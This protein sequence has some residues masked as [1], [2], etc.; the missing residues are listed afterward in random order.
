MKLFWSYVLACSIIFSIALSVIH[1]KTTINKHQS[2]KTGQQFNSQTAALFM[3][4]KITKTTPLLFNSTPFIPMVDFD[5]LRQQYPHVVGWIVA[6]NT[7]INYPIVLGCDNDFYLRHLPDGTPHKFGAIFM[8]Y[9]HHGD[10]SENSIFIYGHN[11]QSGDQ[12][13]T[14]RDFYSQE[15]YEQ[16][17]PFYIYTP[18]A[19]YTLTLFAGYVLDARVATPPLMFSNENEFDNYIHDVKTQSIF[20]SDITPVFDD[21]LV[22]LCTCTNQ[23]RHER[24]VIIGIL[25][26][27][28]NFD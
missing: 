28:P 17:A 4:K 21:Q 7:P 15:T 24:L 12:F 19:N 10:F 27:I 23:N 6:E 22:F 20:K 9:R 2:I 18:H 5:N 26:S 16:H 25:T 1:G 13:G 14:L 3:P 8:D 11:M